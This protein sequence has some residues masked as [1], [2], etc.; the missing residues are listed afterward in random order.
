MSLARFSLLFNRERKAL[1]I[2]MLSLL[3]KCA[4]KYKLYRMKKLF[5]II[6]D[7]WSTNADAMIFYQLIKG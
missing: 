7:F 5:C 6:Y 2:D 3:Q 1:D 4:G